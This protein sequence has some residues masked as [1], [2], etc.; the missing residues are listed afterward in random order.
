MGLPGR[1][2]SLHDR[3]ENGATTNDAM[4]IAGCVM[5][6]WDGQGTV[7]ARAY[8]A[9]PLERVVLRQDLPRWLVVKLLK[10]KQDAEP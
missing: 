4:R 8:T 9:A 7:C 6:F 5:V 10:K 1:L 3:G 2:F